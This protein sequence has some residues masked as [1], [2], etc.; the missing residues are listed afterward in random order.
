MTVE[1]SN[2]TAITLRQPTKDDGFRLHQLVAECP[3]LDPNSIYCNLLQCSHFADT[4]VA[5]E[6]D[7]E[8]V[9]FISGYR[10]PKQPETL[11]VW[12]VAVHEKGRGQGLAKRMLKEIVGRESCR[13]VT[14]LETTITGDNAA[15]WALFRS[16]ARDLGAELS[17]HEHFERA[18]HFGGQHD[19][20]FLLRIGPF[21]KP[22]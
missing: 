21:T 11:F 17:Y 12:Q 2:T 14:H 8:L 18:R 4:A 10:L 19:S 1:G 5:A 9:G 22:V 13:E 7:G 3:P 16:F 20:E 6:K 15:S